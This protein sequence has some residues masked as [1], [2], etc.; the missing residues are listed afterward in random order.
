MRTIHLVFGLAVY[1]ACGGAAVVAMND[2]NDTLRPAASER[3]LVNKDKHGVAILGYDTV[4]YFAD[5][6]AIRGSEA[7]QSRHG[8]ATYWF[9]TPEH[10]AAFDREPARYAPQYGGYCGDAASINRLSP[11]DPEVWQLV[12]GRLVLQHNRKAFDLFNADLAQNVVKADANWPG[13]V[14]KHGKSARVLVNL[15]RDGVALDGHD[16]V[17]YFTDHQPVLGSPEH[18]AVFNG[19]IYWFASYEHRVLFE[20]DPTRYEPQFGGYCAY[21]ASIGRVSPIDPTIFQIL[22]GRLLLQHTPK[23]FELFNRDPD[24]SLERADQNW[25]GLVE[26]HG[27]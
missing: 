4:A 22:D 14:N 11:V 15:N 2:T 23:A 9:A 18:E 27:K 6:K 13:L 7:Y 20:N 12:D 24:A 10:K 3:V 21:A 19:A 26:Q 5:G 17:A 8:G 25:P 1:V 16:P